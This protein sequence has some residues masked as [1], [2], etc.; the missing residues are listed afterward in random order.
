MRPRRG[1]DVTSEP[2]QEGVQRER[3]VVVTVLRSSGRAGGGGAGAAA[4]AVEHGAPDPAA[5]RATESSGVL[6]RRIRGLRVLHFRQ[7]PHRPH[8]E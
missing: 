2:G 8:V 3:F 4:G 6:P 7:K 5:L 1:N